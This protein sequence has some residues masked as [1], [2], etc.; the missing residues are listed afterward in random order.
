MVKKV[1]FN[2]EE[3]YSVINEDDLERFL[4]KWMHL[5]A[6]HLSETNWT[7]IYKYLISSLVWETESENVYYIWYTECILD[8]RK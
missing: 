7:H 8:I 5:E 3:Y 1:L 2:T 4:G 6:M